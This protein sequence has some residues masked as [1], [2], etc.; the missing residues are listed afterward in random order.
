MRGTDTPGMLGTATVGTLTAGTLGVEIAGTVG[1]ETPGTD[2]TAIPGMVGVAIAGMAGTDTDGMLGTATAGTAT[3]GTLT[4]GTNGVAP[5]CPGRPNRGMLA[6]EFPRL[7]LNRPLSWPVARCTTACGAIVPSASVR[8]R[9]TCGTSTPLLPWPRPMPDTS[10]VGDRA[11]SR[12]PVSFVS[13]E[14]M[15]ASN[16]DTTRR[17][18]TTKGEP[19]M[20]WRRSSSVR[21]TTRPSD[22]TADEPTRP[23]DS[24]IAAARLS[25]NSNRVGASIRREGAADLDR[26]VDG[27]HAV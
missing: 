9:P 15:S 25:L 6:S 3:A 20:A 26:W 1:T 7:P 2:G 16:E 4:A 10:T 18:L 22:A 21:I 23:T 13:T 24:K 19:P 11:L 17:S 14:L 5:V 8:N 12:L 27:M